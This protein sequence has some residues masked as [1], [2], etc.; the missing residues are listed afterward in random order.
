ME[1]EADCTWGEKKLDESRTL[2]RFWIGR[3]GEWWFHEGGELRTGL[4]ITRLI[5]SY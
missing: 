1:L 2:L 3:Q 4:L 5:L